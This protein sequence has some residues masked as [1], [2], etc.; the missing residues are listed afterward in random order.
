MQMKEMNTPELLNIDQAAAFLNVK[1]SWL[2]SIVFKK[3]IPVI[4][5]GRLLRFNKKELIQWLEN[6]NQNAI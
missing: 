3:K 1:L 2:R 6:N 5:L 4:R